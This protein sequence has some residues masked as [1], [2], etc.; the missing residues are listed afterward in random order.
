M[1]FYKYRISWSGSIGKWLYVQLPAWLETPKSFF[2]KK[3]REHDWSEHFRGIEYHKV[4]L[5]P[6]EWLEKEITSLRESAKWRMSLAFD[7]ETLLMKIK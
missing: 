2:D 5:P 3:A 4:K 7:Y 6:K 1:K